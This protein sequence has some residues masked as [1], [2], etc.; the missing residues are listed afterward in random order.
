MSLTLT[1]GRTADSVPPS[2]EE[3]LASMETVNAR[4][5]ELLTEYAGSRQYTLQNARFGKEAAMDVEP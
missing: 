4:R 2:G 3:I 1:H 5:H